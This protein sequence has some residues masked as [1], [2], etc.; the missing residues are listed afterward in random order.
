MPEL[1]M[2]I[3]ANLPW[4][5]YGQDFGASAWRPRGGV[6]QPDRR[7]RMRRELGR[8]AAS[9]AT[10]VRWWL[11]GD[12][13]AGLRQ[14]PGTGLNLD[15][16]LA[17][18]VDAALTALRE[19]GLATIF[20]LTDFLW[21]HAPRWVD[22]VRL[23]GLRPYVRHADRRAE[24]LVQVFAP[25]AE[26]FGHEPE[27]AAWDLMNEPEWAILA[28]GTLDPRRAVSRR[29]MRAF[30][31][32]LALLFRSQARQPL[33]V[34]LASARF[35]PL[36]EGIPLD[37]HQV[38]WYESVD[39]PASLAR[40]VASRGLGRPLVLGE[41]PTRGCSLAPDRILEMADAAGYS[42]ALAWSLLATDRVTD[43]PACE[44]ALARWSGATPPRTT[45]A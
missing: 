14:S 34:G 6:A 30:L 4:L 36:L 2:A 26:R 15:D 23:G 13:R 10:L 7:E 22:G 3:G 19:A 29:D 24:L 40:P 32:E 45:R 35:L 37:F 38:H 21:L 41:F 16:C 9:G 31:R 1:A 42:A 17:E 25:L 33:T 44:A 5:D 28:V 27:I 11:L 12:G 43:G 39:S 20:V 18:D 8:L